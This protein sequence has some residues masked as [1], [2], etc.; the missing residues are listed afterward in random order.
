[1][2]GRAADGRR[3][4]AWFDQTMPGHLIAAACHLLAADRT[5]AYLQTEDDDGPAGEPGAHHEGADSAEQAQRPDRSPNGPQWVPLETV[6]ALAREVVTQTGR[7]G[8]RAI[9]EGVRARGVPVSA[10]RARKVA[11]ILLAERAAGLF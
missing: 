3:W 2:W 9:A 1:M 8:P 10:R 5:C 7:T 11:A 6:L 4:R